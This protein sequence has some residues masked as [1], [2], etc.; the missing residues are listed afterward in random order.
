MERIKIVDGV[1]LEVDTHADHTHY[2][3]AGIRIAFYDAFNQTLTL[4]EVTSVKQATMVIKDQLE[5][6]TNGVLAEIA[7]EELVKILG[8]LK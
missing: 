3:L 4:N 8:G 2:T 6:T 1:E 5:A 7:L